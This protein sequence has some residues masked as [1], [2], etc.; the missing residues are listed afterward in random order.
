[1][2]KDLVCWKDSSTRWQTFILEASPSSANG[3]QHL[4]IEKNLA[5]PGGGGAPP[6]RVVI[7]ETIPVEAIIYQN[8]QL[9][10]VV[11]GGNF[12]AG[13]SITCQIDEALRSYSRTSHTFQH[14]LS[15]AFKR[16]QIQT[17][18]ADFTADLPY[19]QVS[20]VPSTEQLMKAFSQAQEWVNE[21]LDVETPL[22]PPE[23][24]LT[25]DVA[26][27]DRDYNVDAR[28]YRVMQI[29]GVTNNVCGGLHVG[30][31]AEIIQGICHSVSEK[32]DY[33]SIRFV[34]GQEAQ[35]QAASSST[36]FAK[37]KRSLGTD[38][39]ELSAKLALIEDRLRASEKT[40]EVLQ[41]G[42]IEHVSEILRPKVGTMKNRKVL[43]EWVP[44]KPKLL[45]FAVKQLINTGLDVILLGAKEEETEKT[46]VAIFVQAD[47]R[48]RQDVL[49]MLNALGLKGGGSDVIQAGAG[50]I[51]PDEVLPQL[52]DAI[53][54]GP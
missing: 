9:R 50:D 23:I 30:N 37:L 3:T 7:D 38:G 2:L 42:W 19:L 36:I 28:Y 54:S 15:E 10:F 26:N 17:L 1:M 51:L 35:V 8:D 32:K 27:S 47:V 21:G 48:P 31:T 46:S 22:L 41:K 34:V 25:L 16:M 11:S 14:L 4:L 40:I 20:P 24:V 49:E 6:D 29:K 43:A 13:Q 18:K 5:Y 39:P 45:R 53:L 52:V 33:A 12:T 44:V